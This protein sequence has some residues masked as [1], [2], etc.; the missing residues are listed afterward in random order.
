MSEKVAV[1]SLRF[2]TSEFPRILSY[3]LS[4]LTSANKIVLFFVRFSLLDSML[5]LLLN[6][7]VQSAAVIQV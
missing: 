3:F 4:Y 6:S 1:S 2:A 5:T 7:I